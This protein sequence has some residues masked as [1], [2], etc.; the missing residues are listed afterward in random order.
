MYHNYRACNPRACE[1]QLEKAWVCSNE[2]P[3]Q[4]KINLKRKKR[5][6]Q[7]WDLNVGSLSPLPMQL[8]SYCLP[9]CCRSVAKS[10]PTLCDPQTAACQASLSFTVS[11]SL[12]RLISI[13]SVILSNHLTL[14]CPLLFLPSVFPSI[15]VFCNE[16]VL[17]IRWPKYWS[18][19]FSMS[20][21]N[22]Y[23]GLTAFRIDLF[24][25]LVVQRTLKSLLQHH[26]SKASIIRLST[27]G[28]AKRKNPLR[29]HSLYLCCISQLTVL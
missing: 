15:R 2:D 13:E 26:S 28:S 24:D 18:F 6:W 8:A 21:S 3:A 10:C 16:S 23:L 22:E 7:G 17:N 25:L 11:H 9:G 14:C 27:L 29:P 19:S 12:L 20:P 1:P 4:A 5:K